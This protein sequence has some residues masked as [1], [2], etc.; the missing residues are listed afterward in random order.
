MR[1]QPL[2]IACIIWIAMGYG[3]IC[4]AEEDEKTDNGTYIDAPQDFVV[5]TGWHALCTDSPD[6]RMHG[7]KADCDCMRAQSRNLV[8]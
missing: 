1:F 2:A 6:C 5:C 4:L 7:D 3:S 8:K